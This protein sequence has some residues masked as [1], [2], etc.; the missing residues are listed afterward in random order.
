MPCKAYP[1]RAIFLALVGISLSACHLP[2]QMD[3]M[4][5][6]TEKLKSETQ[7]VRQTSDELYDALRQGTAVQL[8]TQLF[9]T[10]LEAESTGRKI[11]AAVH[12]LMSF[13]YQLY[14]GFAND[15]DPA[16]RE[17]FLGEATQEF[18]MSLKD[19]Y[20]N[21]DQVDP[22]AQGSAQDI[23]G[24]AN[25][26]ATFNAISL[27][28]HMLNRKQTENLKG[29]PQESSVSMLTMIEDSLKFE[30]PLNNN[31]LQYEQLPVFARHVLNN[32]KMAIKLLQARQSMAKA[33]F[34]AEASPLLE[35]TSQFSKI[36]QFGTMNTIGWDLKMNDLTEAQVN[37]F[38]ELLSF[39]HHS[40]RVLVGLGIQPQANRWVERMLRKMNIVSSSAESEQKLI[41]QKQLILLQRQKSNF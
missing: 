11:A 26:D 5:Q 24:L 25:K 22:L 6:N 3:G 30:K 39:M 12:Y 10:L 19:V 17:H 1:S 38:L 32:K 36:Y 40:Q 15:L 13:E 18:F 35:G 37:S 31:Q 14:T 7:Q 27:G 20:L 34:L 41:L 33:V 9:K 21:T 16:K 4:A 8:R 28:L 23:Y 2:K 29:L